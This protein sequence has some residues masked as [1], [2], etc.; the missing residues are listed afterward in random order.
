[1]NCMPI[2][3]N[4]K[5]PYKK[6]IFFVLVGIGFIGAALIFLKSPQNS[7][8]VEVIEPTKFS[9]NTNQEIVVEIA[10]SVVAPGVYKLASGSRV[11]DLIEK[12]QGFAENVDIE[13]VEKTINRAS[14]LKDGQKFYIPNLNEHTEVLSAT[15]E[16]GGQVTKQY[17]RITSLLSSISTHQVRLN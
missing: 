8:K 7:S 13:W 2:Q 1:M 6:E 5:I 4:F 11:N 14:V 10:G 9:S 15:N 12:S 17:H 3:D 16:G